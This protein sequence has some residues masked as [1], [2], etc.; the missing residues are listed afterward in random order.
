MQK[1]SFRHEDDRPARMFLTNVFL[2]FDLHILYS[3]L[4]HLGQAPA[5]HILVPQFADGD[6][7]AAKH[8]NSA[9]L[10]AVEDRQVAIAQFDDDQIVNREL[11]QVV[12][13]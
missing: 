9:F 1:Q 3:T 5:K 6:N 13:H 12:G 10:E 8:R 11:V 7:L 4:D 2:G